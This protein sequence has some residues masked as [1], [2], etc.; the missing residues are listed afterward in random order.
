VIKTLILRLLAAGNVEKLRRTPISVSA[1][2]RKEKQ[3]VLREKVSLLNFC[4]LEMILI[5]HA[6]FI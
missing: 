4:S 5:V 1:V 3:E 6:C 2:K